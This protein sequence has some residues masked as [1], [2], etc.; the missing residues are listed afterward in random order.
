MK[1]HPELLMDY[2]QIF[3]IV[4]TLQVSIKINLIQNMII[5]NN[6]NFSIP[7]PERKKFWREPTLE[8]SMLLMR[9]TG[10]SQMYA[11]ILKRLPAS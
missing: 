8:S 6:F 4:R 2:L 9:E 1:L 11:E 7:G 3:K 5:N 10:R